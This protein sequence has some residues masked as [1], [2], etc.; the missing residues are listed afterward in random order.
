MKI[1]SDISPYGMPTEAGNKDGDKAV[2]GIW[3]LLAF[4]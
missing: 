4:L 3:H 1:I 2:E